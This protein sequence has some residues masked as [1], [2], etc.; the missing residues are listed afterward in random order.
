MGLKRGS[1]YSHFNEEEIIRQILETLPA[2]T[3]FC[4]D[5]AA[6]DGVTMSNTHALFKSGWSGLAV[7]CDGRR[8]RKLVD[9][10][11]RF[12]RAQF[13][14]TRVTPESVVPLLKSHAVP[15]DFDFLSLDIDGY[16]HFVLKEILG[17]YRPFLICAEVN[18]KI[19][20][21]LKFTVKYDP[22]YVWGGDHF[23][24]QSVA[25]LEELAQEKNYAL[26]V[27][28]YNNAFLVPVEHGAHFSALS[29]A[30]AY[31]AGYLERPDRLK[32]MPWNR[33]ME[34]LQSLT[35]AEGLKFVD[36]FFEKHAGRYTCRI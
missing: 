11:A 17:S 20:P 28:E 25:M 10:Y 19:P 18:E 24:G 8:F 16:D 3:S 34:A 13:A 4:V 7:E 35:P 21:P 5:I 12:P 15:R 23:Y 29:A 22:A 27:L 14:K 2:K 36:R 33:D 9:R 26:I 1:A 31:R 6:G 32:R 30:E